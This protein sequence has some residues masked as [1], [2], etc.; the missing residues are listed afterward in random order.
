MEASGDFCDPALMDEEA[1][2]LLLRLERDLRRERDFVTG[3]IDTLQAVVLV[4][5]EDHRIVRANAYAA[6]TSGIPASDLVGVDAVTTFFAPEARDAA[7]EL[8]RS[9]R[10]QAHGEAGAMPLD[11]P[12]GERR[13]F[14]WS[15]SVLAD[16]ASDHPLLVLVGRDMTERERLF[17][18]VERLSTTD[19]LT[20][21]SNRR[22]LD[23]AGH[24]EVLRARRHHRPLAVVMMDID[25]FKQVNDTHGHAAGDRVLVALAGLCVKMLRRTDLKARPGGDEFCL[26]LPETGAGSALM[27][28]ERIRAELQGLPFEESGRAFRVAASMGVAGYVGEESLDGLLARADRA[29]YLA[30]DTGRN[31]VVVAGE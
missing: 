20:G 9:A 27:L 29:L 28:A 22:H 11:T 31:R 16:P 7:R 17:R 12:T 1:R 3:V 18:E 2:R 5:G 30:K 25:H 24:L 26:L 13:E 15:H 23:A 10:T 8:L 4:V 6:G 21:L 14:G 19:P